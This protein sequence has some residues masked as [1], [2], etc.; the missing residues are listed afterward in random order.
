MSLIKAHKRGWAVAFT[1]V[2]FLALAVMPG[3]PGLPYLFG[4]ALQRALL[5]AL[6]AVFVSLLGGA[7]ALTPSA[8]GLR[9]ALREG[10]YPVLLV[11]GLC[12]VELVSL[13]GLAATGGTVPISPDWAID[14]LGVALLCVSV[15]L[16]EEALFRVLLLGGLLRGHGSTRNGVMSAALVS[17]VVFGALHVALVG[18]LSPL[19]LVQ[20]LLKTAQATCIALVFSAVYVRTR[21]FVGVVVLHALS[22]FFPMALL[23]VLGELEGSIGSYVS[24]GEGE[25]AL[26][27]GLVLVGAYVVLIAFYAPVAVHAWKLLETASLPAEGPF[28]EGWEPRGDDDPSLVPSSGDGLPPRPSGL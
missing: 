15:G 10:R 12:A 25:L 3:I 24:G 22:D 11:L 4:Q 9:R 14:L 7:R 1:V 17:S 26:V 6:V 21:S 20:M 27:A 13:L 28:A 5:F 19:V 8:V 2:G 23:A 16:Y 18:Q